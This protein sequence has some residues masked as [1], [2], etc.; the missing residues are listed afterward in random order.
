MHTYESKLE[1]NLD[2]S[3]VKVSPPV[4]AFCS[5]SQWWCC[6]GIRWCCPHKHGNG[7]AFLCISRS[8]K[9]E[10]NLLQHNHSDFTSSM[11]AESP[12]RTGDFQIEVVGKFMTTA[13]TNRRR[14]LTF[15]LTHA[16]GLFTVNSARNRRLFKELATG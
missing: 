7:L 10:G 5:V 12:P 16:C 11:N 8:R 13:S 6:K 14:T 2:A 15:S 3:A 4:G 9:R 1:C